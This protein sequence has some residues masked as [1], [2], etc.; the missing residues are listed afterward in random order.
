[1]HP[2]S[3]SFHC[4]SVGEQH[5]LILESLLQTKTQPAEKSMLADELFDSWRCNYSKGMNQPWWSSEWRDKFTLDHLDAAL[6][7]CHR[8]HAQTRPS[9]STLPRLLR[10][11]CQVGEIKHHT[12]AV[13]S[14]PKGRFK[15]IPASKSNLRRGAVTVRAHS[16]KNQYLSMKTTQF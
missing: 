11:S 5:A 15:V 7:H 6:P 8:T 3:R 14:F 9:L 12:L 4:S 2:W 1:V 16:R 13:A 10:S